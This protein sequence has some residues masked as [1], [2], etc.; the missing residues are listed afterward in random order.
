MHTLNSLKELN[1]LNNLV[2]LSSF[3]QQGFPSSLTSL[4]ITGLQFYQ[5]MKRLHKLTSLR[6][7][8]ISGCKDAKSFPEETKAIIFPT[9]LTRLTLE[10]FVMLESLSPKGF[11]NLTSLE[12]LSISKCHALT[13]FPKEGLLSSI[14]ELHISDCF[15]LKDYCLRYRSRVMSEMANIPYVKIDGKFIY[16]PNEPSEIR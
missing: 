16:N 10:N 6:S 11:R 14:L 2:S 12:Y 5:V 15:Q 3:P 13:S 4:S 1:I 7:L 8:H 9:C